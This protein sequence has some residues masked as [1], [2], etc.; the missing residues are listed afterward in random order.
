M[1]VT[2]SKGNTFC[3]NLLIA[4]DGKHSKVKK[5]LY[6]HYSNHLGNNGYKV[7]RGTTTNRISDIGFQTWGPSARFA[8]VPTPDQGNAWYAA[9]DNTIASKIDIENEQA[10]VKLQQHFSDWHDPIGSLLL[11]TTNG[12]IKVDDAT[13]H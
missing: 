4:A 13:A 2:T 11:N 6:T 7:Y 5:L 10:L 1:C 12:T 8:C 9:V 3:S